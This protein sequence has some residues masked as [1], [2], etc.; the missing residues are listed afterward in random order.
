M[1]YN[2]LASGFKTSGRRFKHPPGEPSV[3]VPGL[4]QHKSDCVSAPI[5]GLAV[6]LV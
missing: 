3:G 1:G 4:K 6:L 5:C 2:R